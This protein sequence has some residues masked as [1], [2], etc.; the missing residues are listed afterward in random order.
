MKNIYIYA[1]KI[2]TNNY[3]ALDLKAQSNKLTIPFLVLMHLNLHPATFWWLQSCMLPNQEQA[4]I[5]DSACH[6]QLVFFQS[7]VQ[8]ARPMAF[9]HQSCK[10]IH[11]VSTEASIETENNICML[12]NIIMN[13]TFKNDWDGSKVFLY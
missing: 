11:S 9:P 10:L 6:H 8:Q 3:T 12:I 1:S 2:I 13:S 7:P 4:D 5:H